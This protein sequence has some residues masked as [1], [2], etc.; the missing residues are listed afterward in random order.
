VI[1]TTSIDQLHAS[2]AF[3]FGVKNNSEMVDILPNIR[4]FWSGGDNKATGPL[5][6]M[7]TTAALANRAI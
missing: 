6:N 2:I 7:F 1:P 5:S 4:N 3:W